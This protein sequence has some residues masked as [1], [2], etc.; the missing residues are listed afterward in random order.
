VVGIELWYV[1]GQ[2]GLRSKGTLSAAIEEE[3]NRLKFKYRT[4]TLFII[5]NPL[6]ILIMFF[7]SKSFLAGCEDQLSGSQIQ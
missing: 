1:C 3:I 4:K 2:V 6:L 5:T 7:L